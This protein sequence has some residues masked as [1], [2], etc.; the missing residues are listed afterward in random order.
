MHR[1]SFLAAG[2]RA[3]LGAWLL[4]SAACG[5]SRERE[6]IDGPPPSARLVADLEQQLPSLMAVARLPGLGLALIRNAQVAWWKGFGV[7]DAAMGTPVDAATV[8]EVG[9]MSKPVFAYAVLRLHDRNILNLDTPLLTYFSERLLPDEPRL[10]RITARHV[11]AHTTG[12]PNWR[13][14]TEPLALAFTPGE[15]WRYSGEGYAYLQR[16][17]THL[18]GRVDTAPCGRYEQDVRVCATDI[19]DQMR[20]LVLD[21]LGMSSSGYVW[22]GRLARRAARPHDGQGSPMTKKQPTAADAARYASAGGLHSTLQDLTRFLVGILERLRAG[23]ARLRPE[24]L[25]MMVRPVVPVSEQPFRSSWALG[26]QVV[27]L[28]FGEVIAHGG[29]NAGFH[30]FMAASL[31]RKS[32]FVLLTNGDGGPRVIET[33]ATG[34]LME[35]MLEG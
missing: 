4:P 34:G 10:D 31:E 18:I 30:G 11:L 28:P 15:R 17:V 26:W 19:E 22:S 32:G 6:S 2:T 12:L 14:S 5:R 8:F 1:R 24:T 9:S 20:T 13:S 3:A 23:P 21:P 16:V 7:A 29:D 25:E 35:R 33:I 27:H